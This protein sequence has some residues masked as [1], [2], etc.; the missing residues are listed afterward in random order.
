MGAKDEWRAISFCYKLL[1]RNEGNGDIGGGAERKAEIGSRMRSVG[2][3][4]KET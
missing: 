4:S 2:S 3:R 1:P